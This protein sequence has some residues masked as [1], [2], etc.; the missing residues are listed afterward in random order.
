MGRARDISKVFSTNT[1][2][3]TDSEI[4]A[5]NYLTQASASTVYQTKASAGLTLLT[6][7]SIAATG[8]SGSISTNGA[9][10]FTSASAISLN[11]VFSSTYDFYTIQVRAVN[12]SNTQTFN[13]RWRASGSDLT[14][15]NYYHART[16][17]STGGSVTG[18]GAG[19]TTTATI[20]Q[21]A[22]GMGFFTVF[23]AYTQ[24]EPRLNGN[25]YNSELSGLTTFA[26][27]YRATQV[28]DGFTIYP[29][30][31]TITGKVSV[32]GYNE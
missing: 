29:S 8:G 13:W 30:S 14:A 26:S 15:S 3:A 18:A 11:G 24:T 27:G 19:A 21:I 25:S 23:A 31:G 22:T 12:S 28:T 1:A 9:V 7:T 32:Y 2:L 10:S 5:F 20:G 17:T 4:S 16:S 6:P